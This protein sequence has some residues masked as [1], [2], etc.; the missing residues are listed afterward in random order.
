MRNPFNAG[1]SLISIAD[2][3]QRERILTIEEE[4]R[5]LAACDRPRYR[6][7]IPLIICALDTGMRRGEMLKLRWADVDFEKRLISVRAF[8]TKTM[9]QRQVAM[10]NRL[11]AALSQITASNPAATDLVFGIRNTMKN[12][13]ITVRHA[14]GLDD[15]RFH[16]LRHTAATRLVRGRM[17]LAEVGRIL[18]H[19]QPQTTYRYINADEST[20]RR[21]ASILDRIHADESVSATKEGSIN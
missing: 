10:T 19:T 20:A 17:P 15:V 9:R 13:F 11:A 12:G 8:N 1:D 3:R 16:D 6:H 4:R 14:A 7:L 21:A 18:G 2:E 5:L